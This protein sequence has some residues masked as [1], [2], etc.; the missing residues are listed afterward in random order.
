M[1]RADFFELA[2]DNH[3]DEE[4]RTEQAPFDLVHSIKKISRIFK[5]L[6]DSF[7]SSLLP[8][9]LTESWRNFQPI[10]YF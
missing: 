5:N 8:G 1:Q 9:I 4:G 3:E 7:R 2:K 10:F 6:K